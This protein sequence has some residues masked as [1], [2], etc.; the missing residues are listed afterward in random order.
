VTPVRRR[1]LF[2]S[3]SGCCLAR[4][5][6]QRLEKAGRFWQVIGAPPRRGPA[7]VTQLAAGDQRHINSH[8]PLLPI[9]LIL[10]HRR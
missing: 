2:A 9:E 5:G 1:F 4:L 10:V 8:L 7:H 6:Q 3:D